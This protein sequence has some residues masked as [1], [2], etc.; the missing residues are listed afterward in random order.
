LK[1][2]LK[3]SATDAVGECAM[4]PTDS[5]T[6]SQDDAGAVLLAVEEQSIG[7]ML[8]GVFKRAGVNVLWMGGLGPSLAWLRENPHSVTRAFVDCP[9]VRDD[10]VDFCRN[11]LAVRPGLQVLLAGGPD[12]R[13][14]ALELSSH[15]STLFVPKPYLPTELAWQLRTP[16]LRPQA[17]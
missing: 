3:I 9:C 16:A 10:I 7:R 2:F 1:Q 14:T 4:R 8:S 5:S 11:A 13:A 12:T 6:A 17:A 15:G